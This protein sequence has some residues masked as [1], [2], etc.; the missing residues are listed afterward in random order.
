MADRRQE[1][2]G[3]GNVQVAGD[4]NVTIAAVTRAQPSNLLLVI[5]KLDEIVDAEARR[6]FGTP[7]EVE[8]KLTFNGVTRYR[9]FI[10]HY[11]TYGHAVEGAYTALNNTDPKVT[12]R[13]TRF[14]RALYDDLDEAEPPLS[15]DEILRELIDTLR[16]RV[17]EIPGLAAEEIEPSCRMLVAH[18]FISCTVL[19]S[20]S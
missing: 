9:K 6:A 13:V 12:G 19:K 7:S 8:E 16:T 15:S 17:G 14:I 3:D 10:E 2:H 20:V 5:R 11:G 18:A 4:M 1:L